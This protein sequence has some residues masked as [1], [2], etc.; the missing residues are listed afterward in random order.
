MSSP[1]PRIESLRELGR[2][3]TSTVR[4]ARL[5]EALEE[6]PKGSLVAVKRLLPEHRD[7]ARARRALLEEAEVA[8]AARH[9]SLVR[10]LAAGEDAEGPFLAME[11]LPGVDLRTLL[12]RERVLPEG[13]VRRFA[14]ELAGA[15][16][17]LHATG[18]VHGDVKPEN[19]RLDAS[20][21]AVLLDLGF[22]RRAAETRAETPGTL[23][24]LAPEVVRG[25]RPT[26]AADVFALGVLAYEL[27]TGQ[28]PLTGSSV[29]AGPSGP[30]SLRFSD[31][32]SLFARLESGRLDPPSRHAPELS[33]LF[34][35][36]V[37]QAMAPDPRA[38]P[39]APAL[40]TALREGEHSA[41]WRERL[42]LVAAGRELPSPAPP[43]LPLV[44]RGRAFDALG[45]A[46]AAVREP[47]EPGG[48]SGAAVWLAGPSGSGKS[49]L[50]REFAARARTVQ[51]PPLFLYARASQRREARPL[52]TML[53]LLRRWLVLPA[54]RPPGARERDVLARTLAPREAEVLAAA[55][56][57]VGE[58]RGGLP[59]AATAALVA[60]L[61]A[62]A[63]ER[64]ALVFVDDVHAAGEA[65]LAALSALVRE[66]P[67]AELMLVV[68]VRSDEPVL[69]PEAV[70]GLRARLRE[71][72]V[73]TRPLPLF[74]VELGPLEE[75]DVLALVERRFV[76]G[77]PR[78]RL[79]RVLFERSLGNPGLLAEI[80]DS[81]AE[82]GAVAP[83]SDRHDARLTLSI[84]P[85]DVPSP[86]SLAQA[87]AERSARLPQEERA[88][89]ARLAVLGGSFDARFLA[90]AF[91]AADERTAG[92]LLVGFARSGWLARVEGRYRFARPALREALYDSLD[93]G[94]RAE[95]H[96]RISDALAR[97]PEEAGW[98]GVFQRAF[99][100]RHAG[101]HKELVELL[102][103]LLP[104][105]PEI[106]QPERAFRIATWG[107]EACERAGDLP[108]ALMLDLLETA[109][110]AANRLGLR[111]EEREL[112]D[113]MV[114]L[115]LDLDGDPASA[116]RV[117]LAH[118]RYAQGRG[119]LGLARGWLKNAADFAER[120]ASPALSCDAL[121][122]LAVVHGLA[123]ELDLAV[124]AAER[125]LA[126]AP[127]PRRRAFSALS[128][129]QTLVLE[130]RFDEALASL[131]LAR[132]ELA[133]LP[134]HGVLGAL[135][136]IDMLRAR[137]FRCAGRQ[138]RALGA[139]NRAVRR[140]REAGD[141][142]LEVEASARLGALFIDLDQLDRAETYLRDALHVAGE[143][144]D[145][146]GGVL[147][148]TWLGILLWER[149]DARAGPA[150]ERAAELAEAIGHRR[151]VALAL[152][153][154]ARLARAAGDLEA[155][156]D[157]SG[158]A[159]ELCDRLGA[160]LA[161]RIVIAGTR[162]LVL[163]TAGEKG[164]AQEVQ[165]ALRRSV[166]EA[167]RNVADRD[168]A[169]SFRRYSEALME[170]VLSPD[171]PLYPRVPAGE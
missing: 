32:D 112:L 62:V 17:A 45:D 44:G 108:P 88:W 68:G 23:G 92:Q 96:A 81:L 111:R 24:Y 163:R 165:R 98:D 110:G 54:G 34:D 170:A 39:G 66:L 4:L 71:H 146:A 131:S 75:E 103:P 142:P 157:E 58:E 40:E 160:E 63:R 28:H 85:D 138:G 167:W 105:M 130:N 133:P 59:P 30:D 161:D 116:S 31:A 87:V 141:R 22:A 132:A 46:A 60:W 47:A 151:V 80:L 93:E 100:L 120:A 36:L 139:A 168:L 21:R 153:V 134:E 164:A 117:Y 125:A 78:L 48:P 53:H 79:A 6:W 129:A 35:Q 56:G 13:Q 5:E 158:R 106:G 171:G 123:G 57:P 29:G 135:A 104:E 16:A 67:Q 166:R 115:P 2:G 77:A 73:R 89:L 118:G 11:L 97:E 162:A 155:A 3:A 86:V 169:R 90:R 43:V 25:A 127:D 52:G 18:R 15:L 152:S 38:R 51:R 10:V 109:H 107:I 14:E 150:I 113:R 122:R 119:E 1:T 148:Q 82:S 149:D 76:P 65:T 27:A 101:R 50:V 69:R 42:R 74:E 55:L 99:H 121:R 37:A 49:R 20:G 12:E 102:V 154:H 72:A 144:E 83:A 124:E 33:P 41:F 159:L 114:E 147:A 91:G 126:L 137:V 145:R 140:A 143:I 156:L 19:A 64:P 8:R 9:P 84:P 94:Q 70:E 61:A 26:P 7:D 128:R 136:R 95:L